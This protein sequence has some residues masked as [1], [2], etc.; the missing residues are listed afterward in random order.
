MKKN[1][2]NDNISNK[3]A[4]LIFIFILCYKIIITRWIYFNNRNRLV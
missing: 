2:N 1:N 4:Y 3:F